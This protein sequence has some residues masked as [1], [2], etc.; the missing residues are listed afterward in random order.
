MGKKGEKSERDRNNHEA[1]KHQQCV[2]RAPTDSNM[3]QGRPA[4]RDEDVAGSLLGRL[5]TTMSAGLSS[6]KRSGHAGG[7]DERSADSR[8]VSPFSSDGPSWSR[9][10]NVQLLGPASTA[11]SGPS[12]ALLPFLTFLRGGRAARRAWWVWRVVM[13]EKGAESA[14][15]PVM[16]TIR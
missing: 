15:C 5:R 4:D 7:K 12:I 6:A 9:A 2:S 3:I 10:T 11:L 1:S 14:V 8:D 13:K 16:L